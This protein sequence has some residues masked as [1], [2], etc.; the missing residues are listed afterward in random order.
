MNTAMIRD[1]LLCAISPLGDEALITSMVKASQNRF[2][3]PTKRIIERVLQVG[4]LNRQEHLH[5]ASV[6]LASQRITEEERRQ[7]NRI[8]DDIQSGRIKLV[9]N[10]DLI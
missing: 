2:N 7:I 1:L 4:H 10:Q 9:D 8:F 5:L 3:L 6:L